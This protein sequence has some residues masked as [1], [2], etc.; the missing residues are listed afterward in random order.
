[1]ETQNST[2]CAYLAYRILS[3]SSYQIHFNHDCDKTVTGNYYLPLVSVDVF[4]L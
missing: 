4:L 3:V 1:M 2:F